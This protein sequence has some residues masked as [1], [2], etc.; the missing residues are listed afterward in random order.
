[1][2]DLI[3][4]EHGIHG[5]RLACARSRIATVVT[6]GGF[7]MNAWFSKHVPK[8]WGRWWAARLLAT[9]A[10]SAWLIEKNQDFTRWQR[11]K[12]NGTALAL[13][14][15]PARLPVII[16]IRQSAGRVGEQ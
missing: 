8:M 2:H 13:F 9:T 6:E 3:Q 12:R 15:W 14:L 7:L 5:F 4:V 10:C 11:V 1:M 16:N